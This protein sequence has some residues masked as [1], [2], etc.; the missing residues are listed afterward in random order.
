MRPRLL[1]ALAALALSCRL[2]EPIPAHRVT[3]GPE[4]PGWWA[5]VAACAGTPPLVGEVRWW[6][7]PGA[8]FE[9][10]GRNVLAL[11]QGRDIWIASAYLDEAHPWRAF[12]VQH[13]MLHVLL[14][15][16]PGHPPVFARCGLV[17]TVS[18]AEGP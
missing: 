16:E 13:E 5:E 3:P 2:V 1:L 12:V 15:P 17:W 10:H 14:A 6:A 18:G 8:S 9:V 4:W 11:T 7:V